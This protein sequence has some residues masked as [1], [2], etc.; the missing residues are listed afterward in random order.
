MKSQPYI[1][2]ILYQ[3][4]QVKALEIDKQNN[5]WIG[6][7]KGLAVGTINE[8]NFQRYTIMDS[9]TVSIITALYCDPNGDMWIGNGSKGKKPGLIKYN[10]AKKNF[11]QVPAL[12]GIIP[13]TMVMD[14]KGV[15]W[16]GTGQGLLSFKNDSI[17]STLNTG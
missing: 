2:S 17:I 14:S 6:T 16:I 8:Q 7:L 15:L 5:L 9:L 4:G 11:R 13:K 12:S 3:G 1:N 10:A